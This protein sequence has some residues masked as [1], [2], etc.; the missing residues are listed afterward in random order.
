MYV[1]MMV[2]YVLIMSIQDS[3]HQICSGMVRLN[4]HI[5]QH[6]Q[7][8]HLLQFLVACSKIIK[9]IRCFEISLM[10]FLSNN[11]ANIAKNYIIQHLHDVSYC[12]WYIITNSLL[13]LVKR[14]CT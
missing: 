2:K 13:S 5:M 1:S 11:I 10:Q 7:S 3:S 6:K 9:D 8:T 12:T 4:V 14:L